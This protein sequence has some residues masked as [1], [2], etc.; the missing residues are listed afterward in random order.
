MLRLDMR[1]AHDIGPARVDDDKL[2]AGAAILSAQTAFHPAGENGVAIGGVRTNDQDDIAVF[3]A[4]KILRP[5]AG[6]KGG[7]E[8]ISRRRM[9]HARARIDVVI[10]KARTHKFLHKEGFFVGATA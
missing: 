10:A 8:A 6:A 7:F 3:D 4:V 5:R 9:T 2:C 1:R